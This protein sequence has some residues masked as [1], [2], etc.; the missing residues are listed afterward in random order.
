MSNQMGGVGFTGAL[1]T[2]KNSF[3]NLEREPAAQLV[4][5][6]QKQGSALLHQDRLPPS[7]DTLQAQVGVSYHE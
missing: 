7:A 4:S 3:L 2:T 5:T 6:R 1:S